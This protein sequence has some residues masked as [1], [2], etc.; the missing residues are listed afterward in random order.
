MTFIYCLSN[1]TIMKTLG[2]LFLPLVVLGGF[3]IFFACH[4]ESSYSS[5][6]NI[7]P[8][9]MQLSVFLT[10]GPFNFQKVLVDI[11]SVQVL[12]DT[13]HR[14]GDPDESSCSLGDGDHHENGDD[15][16]QGDENN[17]DGDNHDDHGRRSDSCQQ[18]ITLQIHP[19]TYDLMTLRNGTDTL[20]AASFIPKGKVKQ[21]KI[22]LGTD[23]SVMV[24]SVTKPLTICGG[25]DSVVICLRNESLDSIASNNFHLLVD[26]N[27]ARS[28]RV[29]DSSF[30]LRPSLRVFSEKHTG[31]IEGEVGP[32]NGFGL[33]KA[34]NSTDTAFALP[35]GD[36]EGEFKIRGLNA[37]TYSVWIQ[38]INGYQDSTITGVQVSIGE[39][40]KIGR[41]TLHK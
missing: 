21:I 8:G 14:F 37:G 32:E 30:C 11:K 24:D 27:V 31:S 33:V 16:H 40:T 39:E 13:C 2:R 28:I 34:F 4:K 5:S 3:L 38:G 41:V 22:I 36:E 29:E 25:K 15:D 10:D 7:P 1:S 18:W 20:L 35:D 6:A 26:F 12:V 23:N 9:K 17:G 19:G